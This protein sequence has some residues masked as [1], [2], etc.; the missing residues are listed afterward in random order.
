MLKPLKIFP[1]KIATRRKDINKIALNYLLLL[2]NVE[3]ASITL[4]Y[5]EDKD[6][7]PSEHIDFFNGILDSSG[8]DLDGDQLPPRK[9]KKQFNENS[10][11]I[12]QSFH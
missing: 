11:V 3:S 4:T 6:Y 9:K 7:N 2:P 1:L 10:E 5:M 8:S 12:V